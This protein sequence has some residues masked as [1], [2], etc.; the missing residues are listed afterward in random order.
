MEWTNNGN[1]FTIIN[2]EL[3]IKTLP[4]YFRTCNYHSFVRQLNLYGFKKS[5]KGP[6]EYK[7][8]FFRKLNKENL[9]LLKRRVKVNPNYFSG[10][11]DELEM[12][13][14]KYLEI[15]KRCNY[16]FHQNNINIRKVR[17]LN[18]E[19]FYLRDQVRKLKG[20]LN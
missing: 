7:H 11:Y 19:V 8:P 12:T 15:N 1:S 14:E 5:T 4:K 17:E 18:S 2:K 9:F 16:Y 13:P 3:L 6:I 20:L 10:F